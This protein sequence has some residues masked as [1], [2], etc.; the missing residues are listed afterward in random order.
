MARRP[1]TRVMKPRGSPPVMNQGPFLSPEL[2]EKIKAA[3]AGIPKGSVSP[4]PPMPVIGGQ[5]GRLPFEELQPRPMGATDPVQTAVQQ[6]PYSYK[7]ITAQDIMDYSGEV[8]QLTP[9]Q[10]AV[11]DVNQDGAID[12]LDAIW[13][14]QM[15]EG[16]RDP[17]SLEGIDQPVPQPPA[18]QPTGPGPSFNFASDEP[19][20]KVRGDR[21]IRPPAPPAQ[22][23]GSLP[24]LMTG[25]TTP[26]LQNI[27]NPPAGP[28]QIGGPGGAPLPQFAADPVQA[29]VDKLPGEP[30]FPGRPGQGPKFPGVPPVQIPEP[31]GPIGMPP[32]I[33]PGG[34]PIG[35]E[36]GESQV[37]D[38]FFQWPVPPQGGGGPTP[39]QL[40]QLQID[41]E[42]WKTNPIRFMAEPYW[43]S[44]N[45]WEN[46]PAPTI[47]TEAG[48]G[49]GGDMVKPPTPE[50]PPPGWP[51]DKPWPPDKPI[52]GPGVGPMCPS[53]KEHIQLANN[54]W[55]LAG[56]LK[57][58]DEVVTSEEPQKVTRVQRIEGAPRC[59]VLFEDSDSIVSSYSHPYF[60]NSKG[61]VE[62]GNLEKGD[63]IGDLVVKDKKPFSDG[64]VISLSVDK[65]ETYMLRGGTEENPVPVLSH[66]KSPMPITPEEAEKMMREQQEREQRWLANPPQPG[67]PEFEAYTRWWERENPPWDPTSCPS[68]EEH[69]QLANNDWILAGEIKVGDE[70]ITSEDPQKVTRVQR[71]EGAP[72]CEVLF[73]ESNSI[74]TSYS[75]PYFVNSKGFVEVGDLKKGDIIGDLVVKDKKPFSDG[76]VISLSVDKAHTYMLQGGT[77]ENPVPALSHNKWVEQPP[78]PPQPPTPPA[79]DDPMGMAKLLW[80]TNYSDAMDFNTFWEAYQKNPDM[81]QIDGTGTA[82]V[83]TGTAP[84]GTG[85]GPVGTGTAPVGTGTAPVGTGTAPVGTGIAPVGTG[86]APVGTGTGPVGTGTGPVGTTA[87][88]GTTM[89]EMQKMI[90]D[91]QAQM[92]EQA[93]ARAAQ[94]AQMSKNYM[95][96]D[97]RIGYNPY[98]SGQ[99]QPDPY[100]PGGVPDMGGITTIPVPQPLTGIGYANYN[101]RRKI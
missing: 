13:I 25:E 38:D 32:G 85:T 45:W 10:M 58:G 28:I 74:V 97:E 73:E 93:A 30:G 75:H 16:L 51:A 101:P 55:I 42:A 87:V 22:K 89:E 69:I 24:N 21:P 19:P 11:A 80:K 82:P 60:V 94:E 53:P 86:T 9:E 44:P 26:S 64:P 8:K 50:D 17:N 100:G 62:V 70:V 7:G 14:N 95:I 12:L 31:V 33:S 76:P 65:A 78:E 59:E 83:G 91:M 5:I 15:A 20:P 1:R 79:P 37:A 98:L 35:W 61:F 48:G 52:F 66:N 27:I 29:A 41:Q 72:R 90:A 81:F 23:P 88:Q 43:I 63:I 39:E 2:G 84:V 77:E 40:A 71:I 57:V 36:P 3:I 56:E 18:P 68:P 54:D 4:Q 49:K 99:Y 34:F 92:Q 46:R 96:S 67:D 6:M 47:D